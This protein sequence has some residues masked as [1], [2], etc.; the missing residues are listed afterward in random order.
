MRKHLF[1]ALGMA[2]FLTAGAY[3][4]DFDRIEYWSGEGFNKAA[5]VVQFEGEN[6]D[7][8]GAIVWGCRWNDGE[9]ITAEEMMRKIAS[10]SPD[11]IMLMQQTGWMGYTL[12]GI[13]YGPSVQ[14]MLDNVYFDYDQAQEDERISFGYTSP[15]T[16]MGQTSAPGQDA[17]DDSFTAIAEA[18][19][20][21]VIE[22][23]L[24]EN[25]YGY[26]AYDYDYWKMKFVEKSI[27]QSGWYDGYWSFWTGG[28]DLDEL[29]YSALGMSSVNVENEQ[30]IGWKYRLLSD[31][32]DHVNT[33]ASTGASTPWLSPDYTHFNVETGIAD[34]DVE[35]SGAV[36]L[37]RLDGTKVEYSNHLEKGIYILRKGGKSK[38]IYIR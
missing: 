38:M 2:G 34:V 18:S 32:D 10:S 31:S 26:P 27:W 9:E 25:R 29:G 6:E 4:I 13:G 35:N 19:E 30:V 3:V 28:V 12:N 24:S 37:Y 22:H 21:H 23:P 5:L 1:L 16:G 15:N 7:N 11:I 8:P 20:S 14:Q 36:E 17:L 33:D